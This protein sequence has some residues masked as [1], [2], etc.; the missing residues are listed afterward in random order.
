MRRIDC[1]LDNS[2]LS[3]GASRI[4]QAGLNLLLLGLFALLVIS[5]LHHFAVTRSVRTFGILAV[6]VLFLSLYLARRP[7]RMETQSQPLWLLAFGGTAAP[8]LMRPLDSGGV[9]GGTALQLFGLALLTAALLSLR[10]S[11]AVVPSHRGIRVGGL[12]RFVRHPVYL[13]ELT[14]ML[15]ITWS[16]P[17]VRNATVWVCVCVIQIAR[18]VA[19]ERLLSVD[20]IYQSYRD[21]VRYRLIPGLF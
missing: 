6:N 21:R 12:Y 7:A 1:D 8:L 17:S 10:R 19:E 20:P 14:V 4:V 3:R 2:C 15:G 11:F 5:S 16:N 9:A 13:A 18:A